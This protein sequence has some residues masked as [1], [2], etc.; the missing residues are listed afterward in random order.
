M[1]TRYSK[2]QTDGS[3]E[4][5]DSRE[6]MD[7]ANPSASYGEILKTISSSFN[8][9]LAF[10]GFVIAGAAALWFASSLSEW[11]TWARFTGVL[12]AATIGGFISGKFGNAL[13]MLAA[14]LIAVGV[15]FGLGYAVWHL[16]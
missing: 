7:A 5:Y 4:Y 9:I 15:V 13:F 3:V 14:A 11:P 16:L 1:A 8:P 12:C 2:R 6:E 10:W